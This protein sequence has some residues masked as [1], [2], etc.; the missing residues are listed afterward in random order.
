MPAGVSLR[1]V[2]KGGTPPSLWGRQGKNPAK[3]SCHPLRMGSIVQVGGV[4]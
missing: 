4:T 2:A 3:G 1:R